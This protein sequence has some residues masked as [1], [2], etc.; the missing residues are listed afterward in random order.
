MLDETVLVDTLVRTVK[1]L[2]LTLHS[3]ERDCFEWMMLQSCVQLHCCGNLCEFTILE[4][5]QMSESYSANC[6]DS[7]LCPAKI[8][9]SLLDAVK[10]TKH[11]KTTQAK[12]YTIFLGHTGQDGTAS[13]FAAF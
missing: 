12:K 7:F 10:Q 6:Q 9:H 3:L 5:K 2:V 8:R 11:Q 1:V 13:N 4:S